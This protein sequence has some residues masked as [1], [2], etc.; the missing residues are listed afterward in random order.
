MITDVEHG[1]SHLVNPFPAPMEP[2]REIR[3]AGLY[4]AIWQAFAVLLPVRSVG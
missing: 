3:N 1:Q 4:G 2:S